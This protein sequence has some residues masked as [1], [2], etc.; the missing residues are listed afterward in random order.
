MLP[1][2]DPIWPWPWV[3]LAAVVSLVAVVAT[4][5]QRI[6][7]LP[8]GQRKLLMALRLFTW[9]TLTFAMLRPWLEV[10]EI[11][12]HASVFI[13]AVDQSR[14]MSVKDGPAGA[15]RREEALTHLADDE[16]E[17]DRFGREIEIVRVDFSKE[18]VVVES[19]SPET[20]GEQTAIG[21]LLDSIPKLAPGKK[22][23]GVLLFSDGA[24]RALPPYDTDPRAAANRLAEQQ[25]RVD[26]VGL[27]AS[28]I[29]ETST[30][31]IVEDLE[32]S[33]TV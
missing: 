14:S 4:Y 32:V 7:H 2:L 20:P 9:A 18:P 16:R 19:F 5:R 10:T 1:Q 12:R 17:L 21:H 24:Q 25:I 26:V 27:G 29:S 28:G 13:V 3:I 31:L 11:D 33:P 22:V 23:V 6:A 30:D 15:T 8:A